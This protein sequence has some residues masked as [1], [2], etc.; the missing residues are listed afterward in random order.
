MVL[1]LPGILGGADIPPLRGLDEVNHKHVELR[2]GFWAPR[3]KTHE[4]VAVPHALDCL[5]RD[6]HVANFDIAAGLAKEPPHG[7]HAFDSDLH[8]ALEGALYSLEH[9]D[10]PGLRRRVEGILDR[11]LA[12][13]QKDGFLISYFIIQGLDK[14]W[15]DL[16][17]EHQMYNAGHFFEMAVEHDRLTGNPKTLNAAKRFADH[18]DAVFG[19][20]KRY[21]V[22]MAGIPTGLTGIALRDA[23]GHCLCHSPFRRRAYAQLHPS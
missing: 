12:A 7:H 2:G 18:I 8:K 16:R 19:P 15:D 10:D 5:E 13:Q 11:I 22:D 23:S 6:G 9:H 17:L 20:G 14:K 1:S 3:L 21:D 4:E